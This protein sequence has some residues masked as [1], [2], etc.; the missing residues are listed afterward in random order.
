MAKLKLKPGIVTGKALEELFAYCQ[1]AQCA[2]PAVNVIGS[3][4]ANA[5][6]EAARR[7][8]APVI[9]QYSHGGSQFT[10]GKFGG[11]AAFA[12]QQRPVGDTHDRLRLGSD[13]ENGDALVAQLLDDR[14]HFIL[15]ADIHAAGRLVEDHD[16]WLLGQ[17]FGQH[18]FLLVAAAQ[19]PGMEQRL[20][21]AHPH[22]IDLAAGNG[23]FLPLIEQPA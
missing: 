18:H 3:S 9:I 7:A 13:Q 21:R 19:R 6:M 12:H 15:G 5:V 11:E 10:A 14:Q 16:G 17:P 2:L 22:F 4:S 8:S 1:E 20:G 23:D